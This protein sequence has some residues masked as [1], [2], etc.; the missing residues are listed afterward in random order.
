MKA[1]VKSVRYYADEMKTEKQKLD[2]LKM[3][4]AVQELCAVKI[5]GYNA[6]WFFKNSPGDSRNLLDAGSKSPVYDFVTSLGIS[7]YYANILDP[8]IKGI[9]KSQKTN[10]ANRIDDIK[11]S[12]SEAKKK[13]GSLKKSLANAQ[14]LKKSFSA[15]SRTGKFPRP[16]KYCRLGID[17]NGMMKG[18]KEPYTWREYESI[19]D[20]RIRS[21]KARIGQITD[22]LRRLEDRLKKVQTQPPKRAIFGGRRLYKTKDTVGCD[23]EW[24]KSFHDARYSSFTVG[25]RAN[26]PGRNAVII[27]EDGGLTWVL[28]FGLGKARLENFTLVR[29]AAEYFRA[30]GN[31]SFPIAYT[32]S[33]HEDDQGR[34]YMIVSVCFTIPDEREKFDA[35]HGVIGVDLNADHFAWTET[36]ADGRRIRSG[37]IHFDVLHASCGQTDESLGR[38]VAELIGICTDSGK[39]LVMEDLSLKSARRGMRYQGKLRN[40]IISQFAFSKMTELIASRTERNGV[41]VRCINPAY[42][43]LIGKTVYMRKYGISIHEAASYA[44]ALRGMKLEPPLL[45]DGVLALIPDKKKEGLVIGDW[46]DYFRLLKALQSSTKDI[47]KHKFYLPAGKIASLI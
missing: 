45:P 20:S 17:A 46:S 34:E 11:A 14:K 6:F 26:R 28:P 3:K 25:G 13:I 23:A 39:P 42:T 16:Y 29:Y 47:P 43:S 32:F 33:F 31:D 4:A 38:A 37:V 2:F 41:S 21:R 5:R 44:I 19:V 18:T 27:Y 9:Y 40:R 12:I 8:V 10:Q 15:Y 22:R 7:S 35:S 24:K 1:T 36:S 30:L